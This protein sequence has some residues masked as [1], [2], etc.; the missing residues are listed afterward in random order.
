MNPKTVFC[1][2]DDCVALGHI[3]K[4][5][6]TIH[7]QKEK[8]YRCKE[9]GRTFSERKGSALYRLHKPEETMMTVVK[10]LSHGCP[11]PAI[12]AAYELDE[13]TIADWQQKSGQ[14]AK[15]VHEALV[16]QP[17]GINK[18]SLMSSD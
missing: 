12:V 6:I 3:G 10:L 13:R 1:P 2:N 15:S 14:H 5:N 7:S 9:C 8:R 4:G 18:F 11:I 17:R 16:E